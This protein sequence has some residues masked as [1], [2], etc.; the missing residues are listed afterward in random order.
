MMRILPATVVLLSACVVAAAAQQETN[1]PSPSIRPPALLLVPVTVPPIAGAP[2]SATALVDYHQIMPDGSIALS[3]FVTRVARDSRG[4]TYGEI[5]WRTPL[6]HPGVGRVVQARIYDPKTRIRT[7]Y[8]PGAHNAIEQIAP[9]Q[10]PRADAS[11]PKGEMI[12]VEDLG[13]R[14][15]NNFVVKGTRRTTVIPAATSGTGAPVNVVDEYWFS[16]ELHT[17]L[18]Q[19]HTDP[20]TGT[21]TATLSDIKLADPDQAFFKIPSGYHTTNLVGLGSPSSAS[22]SGSFGG[23][24]GPYPI[25]F[26]IPGADI[27]GDI[28]GAW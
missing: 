20:R 3:R 7:L 19:V 26:A 25:P 15:I 8:D 2:L 24:M 16:E 12:T 18:L 22:A 6:T 11:S 28:T 5:R 23:R 17:N 14:T 13:S 9:E 21:R 10:S 27:P 1:E 4:R